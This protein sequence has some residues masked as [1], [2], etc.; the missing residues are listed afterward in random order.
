MPPR[1]TAGSPHYRIVDASRE[2]VVHPYA[3]GLAQYSVGRTW[4]EA[5]FRITF[6][7]MGSQPVDLVNLTVKN[8]EGLGTRCEEFLFVERRAHRQTALMMMM[9]D[10]PPHFAL[11]DAYDTAGDGMLG[12]MGCPRPRTPQRIYAGADALAVDQVA[13]RHMGLKDPRASTILRAACHWFG[14][15][16]GRVEVVGT[17]EPLAGWRGP[18]ANEFRSLLSILSYPVYQFGSGRG[19]LFVPEMDE[20]AFAPI[21]RVG[22]LVR[23]GRRA[24]QAF[25]GLRHSTR[26]PRQPR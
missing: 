21:G 7:K 11:L 4:K 18:Y 22:P 8:L 1:A 13:A 6:G 2:Q 9:D 16:A 25:L 23:L 10:F 12:M 15:P 3:R 24:L 19:K 26:Q 14:D 17:N 20:K 5:D